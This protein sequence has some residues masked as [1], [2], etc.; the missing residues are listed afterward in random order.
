VNRLSNPITINQDVVTIFIA[1]VVNL[2]E[3]ALEV[4]VGNYEFCT[5]NPRSTIQKKL[6]SLPPLLA[7]KTKSKKIITR[8]FIKSCCDLK[9]I[10]QH[11]ETKD[12]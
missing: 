10:L 2:N 1:L 8:L 7:R 12:N 11:Y 9:I 4:K 5:Y 6:L 3:V